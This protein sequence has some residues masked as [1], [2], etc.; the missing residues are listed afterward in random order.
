METID[1][2]NFSSSVLVEVTLGKKIQVFS[3]V[4]I[5]P[6][7]ILTTAQGLKG[8][9]TK[10]RVSW[11]SNYNQNG[12]FIDVKNI[13]KH[14][15][16]EEGM[17]LAKIS[18]FEELPK[19]T[20][21]YPIIKKDHLFQGRIIRVGFGVRNKKY[22]RTLLN[23]FLEKILPSKKILILNDLYSFTGDSGG[24]IFLQDAGQMYLV[25]IH[26]KKTSRVEGK[27]SFNTLLSSQRGW[28]M[29]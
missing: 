23:P 26:S 9:V 15:D 17:D 20:I 22:I 10:V 12:N 24:P 6:K 18:L 21:Y 19:T 4:A 2:S 8:D 13:E 7:T 16:F 1:W 28:I 25:A 3:G 27:Y 11:D 14:P 29:C 5:N